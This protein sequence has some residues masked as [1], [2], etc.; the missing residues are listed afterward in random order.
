MIIV[1]FTKY[2]VKIYQLSIQQMSKQ[3]I[4]RR[5]PNS[6]LVEKYILLNGEMSILFF[7]TRH[8]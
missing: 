5:L 7:E 3:L 1:S 4:I 6:Q 8:H 2:F